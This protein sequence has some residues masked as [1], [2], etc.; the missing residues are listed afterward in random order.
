MTESKELVDLP[1]SNDPITYKEFVSKIE[2]DRINIRRL[3]MESVI[4][5]NEIAKFMKD[6]KRIEIDLVHEFKLENIADEHKFFYAIGVVKAVA[7]IAK[8]VMFLIEVELIAEYNI[9]SIKKEIPDAIYQQFIQN[10]VPVNIWPYAR[11]AIQSGTTKMGYPPLTIR[12][13]RVLM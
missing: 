12:P 5:P 7:R 10:N 8:N 13:Y 4:A 11:E 1:N 6:G 2:I 9:S 3:N